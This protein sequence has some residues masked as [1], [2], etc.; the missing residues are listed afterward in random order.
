MSAAKL[1]TFFV[2]YILAMYL[3]NKEQEK[4]KNENLF[5]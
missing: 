2:I 3:C 4:H 1:P 5:K